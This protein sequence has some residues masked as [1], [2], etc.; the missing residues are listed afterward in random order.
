M[1]KAGEGWRGVERVLIWVRRKEVFREVIVGLFVA[2][3][4]GGV[5]MD[6]ELRGERGR[7]G[8]LGRRACDALPRDNI[9]YWLT[10]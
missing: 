2:I 8:K 5:D 4:T 9:L 10:R 3:V 1:R 6:G 7:E